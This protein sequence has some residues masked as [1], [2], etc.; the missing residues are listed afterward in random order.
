MAFSTGYTFG[1]AAAIC[2][3]AS[4]AVATAAQGLR[5][6]QD[7]NKR[8]D[9]QG[10]ILMALD[11][12]ADDGAPLKGAAIDEAYSTQVEVVLVDGNGNIASD[13]TLDEALAFTGSDLAKK[14]GKTGDLSDE[15]WATFREEAVLAVYERVDGSGNVQAYALPVQGVGL[16]GPIS[17]FIALE[18][19]AS[20]VLGAT[21][22][23]PAETPGLG[24]EIVNT[25]FRSQFPGKQIFT[26]GGELSP[27]SVVKGEVDLACAGRTEFCVQGVSGATMTSNGV[28]LMLEGILS[29]YEPYLEQIRAGGGS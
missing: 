3:T 5:E 22:A 14:L 21:F 16:W 9:L 8:R 28:D 26:D 12:H 17:G 24:Y 7:T 27:V 15:E 29:A 10:S 13:A 6:L 23:A 19:D 20:T 2:V 11:V 1:F 4:L 18:P 25:P